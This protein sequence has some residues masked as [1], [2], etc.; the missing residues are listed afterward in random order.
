MCG[1][2]FKAKLSDPSLL[3]DSID[4]ISEIIHEGLFQISSDSLYL[5]ASDRATVA[6]VDFELKEEAFDE[7]ECDEEEEVG[8]NLEDFLEIL[9]RAKGSDVLTLKLSEDESK[10]KIQIE[11]GT[12]R[13]FDMPLLSMSE[14]EVPETK[15]LEFSAE[16]EVRSSALQNGIKDVEIAADS[17]VFLA[18]DGNFIM[19]SEGDS[20]SV[21]V[22]TEKGSE[23][24][25]EIKVDEKSRSRYPIE[26]L[27]KMLKASKISDVTS[28][29][30]G[31]DYPMKLGFEE[32]GKVDMSFV[33]A[34]RVEE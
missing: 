6:V 27:K 12:K 24:L 8:I 10:L 20:S 34:P 29:K 18:E 19:K 17:V 3:K 13:E 23:D 11:N 25:M 14:G 21:E 7:F 4:T 9:M 32:P 22:K 5:R 31:S 30:F 28:L 15:Q 16:M 33:L 1:K 26:Y 2:I